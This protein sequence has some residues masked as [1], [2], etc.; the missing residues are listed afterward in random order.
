MKALPKT[1]R[2]SHDIELGNHCYLDLHV[3]KLYMSLI[4]VTGRN[5][6]I[7]KDIQPHADSNKF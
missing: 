2:L 6:G 4:Q 7:N 3:N 1:E 5:V